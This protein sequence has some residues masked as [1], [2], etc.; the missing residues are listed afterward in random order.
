MPKKRSNAPSKADLRHLVGWLDDATAESCGYVEDDI[1]RHIPLRTI[2][3]NNLAEYGDWLA[4]V[5]LKQ[6]LRDP[7][8]AEALLKLWDEMG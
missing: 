8:S 2:K 4:R 6:V 5:T 1:E 3:K 7:K